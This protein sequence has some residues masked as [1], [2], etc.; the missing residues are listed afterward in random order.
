MTAET[1]LRLDAGG[2]VW[3]LRSLVAMGHCPNRIARALD[4]RPEAIR[5]LVRGDSPTVTA[6]LRDSACQLWNAWTSGRPRE[7]HASGGMPRLR[8]VARHE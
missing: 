1:R 5:R 3:R 6:E 8:A 7:P 2:T 4:M